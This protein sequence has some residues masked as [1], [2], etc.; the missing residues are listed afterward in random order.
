MNSTPGASKARRI[1]E[2]VGMRHQASASIGIASS[3]SLIFEQNW[4]R[5]ARN[6]TLSTIV[7]YYRTFSTIVYARL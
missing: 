6:A 5:S 1:A 7:L 3:S 2:A 4:V